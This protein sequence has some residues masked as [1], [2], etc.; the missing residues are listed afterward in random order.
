M[1]QTHT[2]KLISSIFTVNKLNDTKQLENR[3]RLINNCSFS[4]NTDEKRIFD[5]IKT[6]FIA[7]KRPF[8]LEELF[9]IIQDQNLNTQINMSQLTELN[10][11]SIDNSEFITLFKESIAAF[12]K[13]KELSAFKKYFEKINIYHYSENQLNQII[14]KIIEFRNNFQTN[15]TK[16]SLNEALTN[17]AK[18]NS[19][20]QQANLN[21]QNHGYLTVEYPQFN[22]LI[23][24]IKNGELIIYSADSGFGKSTFALNLM[25][26]LAD[27][28]KKNNSKNPKITMMNYE[29]SIN[30]II[31]RI[32]A[33]KNKEFTLENEKDVNL[34]QIHS[35]KYQTKFRHSEVEPTKQIEVSDEFEIVKRTLLNLKDNYNFDFDLPFYN[36]DISYIE[37]EI[38]LAKQ[39]D[40]IDI[41]IV[42]HLHLLKDSDES[43]FIER[44]AS[45]VWKLKMLALSLDIP[46]ILLAQFNKESSKTEEKNMHSMKGSSEIAQ[47]A[48][49]VFTL[50]KKIQPKPKNNDEESFAQTDENDDIV[51]VVLKIHK[52]RQGRTGKIEF[53]FDKPH[54]KFIEKPIFNQI[55][56]I[57]LTAQPDEQTPNTQPDEQQDSTNY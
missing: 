45:I 12:K 19:T 56:N 51:D 31:E 15:K 52:N 9:I 17:Y 24:G 39:K 40:E 13:A 50:S 7:N 1:N 42:D 54:Q 16:I 33:L 37:Q 49:V 36:A 20:V 29:M 2:Q 34:T 3:I 18:E 5:A 8:L 25:F 35:E 30:D 26:Q 11:I 38:R 32:L 46:I 10:N 43:N 14:S 21:K 28:S 44:T 53:Q 22:Q 47:Y 57:V 4:N 23:G 27:H 48:N 41:L 55:Q 6:I